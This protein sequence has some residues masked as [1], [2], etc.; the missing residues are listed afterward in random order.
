MWIFNFSA[1]VGLVGRLGG[2][3]QPDIKSILNSIVPESELSVLAKALKSA[4]D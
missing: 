4:V 1:R 2:N 3:K